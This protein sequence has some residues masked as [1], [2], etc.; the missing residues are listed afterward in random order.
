M[1]ASQINLD[2]LNYAGPVRSADAEVLE[3]DGVLEDNGFVVPP[4]MQ[5]RII[6]E[7]FNFASCISIRDR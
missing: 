1:F 5:V 7:K 2:V 3:A 6:F 4:V